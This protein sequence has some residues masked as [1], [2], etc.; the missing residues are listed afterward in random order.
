MIHEL[1]HTFPCA[2][3][4]LPERLPVGVDVPP[5]AC[6]S[7]CCC[8]PRNELGAKFGSGQDRP[9]SLLAFSPL[10]V[11]K[12]SEHQEQEKDKRA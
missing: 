11:H 3:L 4:R 6:E 7:A 2:K 9:R 1:R 8:S 10:N 12:P 5:C